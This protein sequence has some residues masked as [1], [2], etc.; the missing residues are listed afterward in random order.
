MTQD[1]S[2]T[3]VERTFSAEEI[4]VSK[5]DLK[6]RL[7]YANRLFLELAGYSEKE[8]LGQQHSLIRHPDMPRCIFALLWEAIHQGREI[9]AYIVNRSNNGDH[10]WVYAHVTPSRDASGTIIGY[11]SNRRASD[12]AIVKEHIIPLYRELLE[13][14]ARHA[15]R[16]DGLAASKAL[17]A[18]KLAE[19]DIGYDEFVMTIGQGARRG[20]RGA[21]NAAAPIASAAS[22]ET[23]AP[24]EPAA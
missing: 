12:P 5:T 21:P 19:E 2:L 9:F 23:V 24:V 7:T 6:G 3:G 4:I 1:V 10:Y 16:K 17:L 15:N 13:E 20:Y 8:V 18:E 22:V 14:E 11:H